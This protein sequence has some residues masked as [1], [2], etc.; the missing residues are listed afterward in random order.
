MASIEDTVLEILRGKATANPEAL[1]LE[2]PLE[3]AGIDSLSLIEIIFELE[4]AFDITV[5][6][7]STVEERA[8]GM[9]TAGDV[10]TLVNGLLAEKE[11]GTA[12]A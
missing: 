9:K 8:N 6:D 10:V 11:S 7:P 2:S 12:G 3:E 1:T 4:D 5:P